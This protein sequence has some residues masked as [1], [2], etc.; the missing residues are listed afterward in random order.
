VWYI[1][2]LRDLNGVI[3]YVGVTTDPAKRLNVHCSSKYGRE[4]PEMV[5]LAYAKSEAA[6]KRKENLLI[7]NLLSEGVVLH[8]SSPK[9]VYFDSHYELNA[10]ERMIALARE[11]D[12]RN[13]GYVVIPVSGVSGHAWT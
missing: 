1:Y 7:R 13:G 2:C 10:V 8:Q 4:R 5:I 3:T 6:A 9:P 11:F 12:C